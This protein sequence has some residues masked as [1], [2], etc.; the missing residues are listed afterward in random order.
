MENRSEVRAEKQPDDLLSKMRA[1]AS[2]DPPG[3]HV[4]EMR[5]WWA[6]VITSLGSFVGLFWIGAF[7][8]G[9]SRTGIAMLC[10]ILLSWGFLLLFVFT[11]E[12]DGSLG[13]IAGIYS[14]VIIFYGI[15][16]VVCIWGL[17]LAISSFTE[18]NGPLKDG[19]GAQLFLLFFGW[20]PLLFWV[21]VAVI[22]LI[23]ILIALL[24]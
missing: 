2:L 12:G 20:L 15:Y 19:G 1:C 22:P 9:K 18:I 6:V 21:V 14:L 8:L 10:M 13:D 4:S 24:V 16:A 7:L 17:C 5:T 3:D 23:L 11:M